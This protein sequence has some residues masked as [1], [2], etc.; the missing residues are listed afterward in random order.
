M[1]PAAYSL[2]IDQDPDA[3]PDEQAEGRPGEAA[4]EDGVVGLEA[5]G[6]PHEHGDA[7]DGGRHGGQG[8]QRRPHGAELGPF[9]G[10]RLREA[11]PPLLDPALH[12]Q[13]PMLLVVAVGRSDAGLC[14]PVLD[15]GVGHPHIDLL[16]RGAARGQLVQGDAVVGGEP[17]DRRR[18]RPVD[19]PAPL[20][21]GL[22]AGT[23]AFQQLPQPLPVRGP[24]QG[25]G[26]GVVLEEVPHGRVGQQAALADH[27]QLVGRQ[28][29]LAHQVAGDQDRAALGGEAPHQVPDPADPLG[30]QAVDR[31]V[32]DQHPGVAE[33]GGGDPQPL[34][35]AERE[36]P[37]PAG[38][39]RSQADQLQDLAHPAP[40]DPVAPGQPQQM[41]MG[42]PPAVHGPGV[43]QR[44]HLPQRRR[45]L[46]V[47]LAV[48]GHAAAG[49]G[50]QPEDQAHGGGLARPRWAP[51][52]RSPGPAAPG[53]TARPR[54]GCG[55]SAWSTRLL[56]SCAALSCSIGLEQARCG[57]PWS[58]SPPE[59]T[60][61]VAL[62]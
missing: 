10:Q 22:Q 7:E 26:L 12:G 35:H 16:Q 45:Q 44:P 24:D 25:R 11:G 47:A 49:G 2:E 21:V 18:V 51:G 27:Q 33:Q 6:G 46:P 34:R 43:Q 58:A 4:P 59:P 38:G 31:L 15:P 14:R 57:R 5:A 37:D 48:D 32:E 30:V 53:T 62:G 36:A 42:G 39:H 56:R 9:R 61:P 23:L 60:S 52:T 8:P 40:R 55:R 20:T 17:A 13:P 28:L 29:H 41:V 1:V 50:V 3:G 19:P 54:P